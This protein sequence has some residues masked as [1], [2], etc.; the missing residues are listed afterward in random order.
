MA[1]SVNRT[2]CRQAL[3]IG[4]GLAIAS[5]FSAPSRAIDYQPFD[6]VPAPAR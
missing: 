5:V 3:A 4:A 1:R 6:F 2:L